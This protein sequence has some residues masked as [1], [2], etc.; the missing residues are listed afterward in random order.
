MKRLILFF[1]LLM[2]I[3]TFT[4]AQSNDDPDIQVVMKFSDWNTITQIIHKSAVD[5]SVRDP[6]ISMVRNQVLYQLRQMYVRDSTLAARRAKDSLSQ[7]E[8][9]GSPKS[10]DTPEK[11]SEPAENKQATE[12]TKPKKPESK[13]K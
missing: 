1:T 8:K 13:P 4:Q 3:A 5:G 9:L 11:L 7:K 10:K 12:A 2:G 6:L